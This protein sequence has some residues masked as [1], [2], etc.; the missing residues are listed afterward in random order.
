MIIT[1][2]HM[3]MTDDHNRTSHD[4]NRVLHDHD[5]ASQVTTLTTP[6]ATPESLA[7]VRIVSETG[8]TSVLSS[9]RLEIIINEECGTVCSNSFDQ[10]DAE[11]ACMELG[12]L[13][14]NGFT[15]ASSIG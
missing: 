1:E 7:L 2:Y 10:T 12:F 8:R 5:R 4:H 13:G 9:G 11:V 15:T 14:A 3:I 6:T